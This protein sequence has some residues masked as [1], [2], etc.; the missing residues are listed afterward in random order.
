MPAPLR[1]YLHLPEYSCAA[2]WRRE[3]SNGA[4]AS[5]FCAAASLVNCPTVQMYRIRNPFPSP[6]LVLF[7]GTVLQSSAAMRS[8][9]ISVCHCRR[10]ATFL[11]R[12][13]Y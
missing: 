7:I 13:S 8:L 11:I 5:I 12:N 9:L 6:C 1:L 3:F 10:A 2:P 4:H